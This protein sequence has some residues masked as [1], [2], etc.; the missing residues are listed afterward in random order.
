L[1][2]LDRYSAETT[3]R[4]SPAGFRPPVTTILPVHCAKC[5][6]PIDLQVVDW[7]PTEPSTIQTFGCPECK[8]ANAAELAGTIVLAVRRIVTHLKVRP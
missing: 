1:E 3:V 7:D 8:A 2:Y 5:G 4:Y 6:I